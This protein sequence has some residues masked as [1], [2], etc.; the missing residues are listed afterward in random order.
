MLKLNSERLKKISPKHSPPRWCKSCGPKKRHQDTGWHT[1]HPLINRKHAP[2]LEGTCL[3][4]AERGPGSLYHCPFLFGAVKLTKENLQR[5]NLPFDQPVQ[6][7]FEMMINLL[8]IH[9]MSSF[10]L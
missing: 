2:G 4:N 6:G 1:A 5:R 3:R 10:K 8:H 9:C 7:R